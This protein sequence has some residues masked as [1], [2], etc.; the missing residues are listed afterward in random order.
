MVS[1]WALGA[2][3]ISHCL[4][5]LNSSV[6]FFIYA[7]T[8]STFREVLRAKVLRITPKP[9]LTWFQ[10]LNCQRAETVTESE[11][12]VNMAVKLQKQPLQTVC[13]PP[14]NEGEKNTLLQLHQIENEKTIVTTIPLQP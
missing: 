14:K 3:S 7:F 9:V 2:A 1:L 4:M 13:T 10:S 6:N 12:E 11:V 5:S 8:S